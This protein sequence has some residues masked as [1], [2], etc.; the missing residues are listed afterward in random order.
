[1]LLGLHA[2]DIL[3]ETTKVDRPVL[4][5][6]SIGQSL[7]HYGNQLGH[8]AADGRQLSIFSKTQSG[9]KS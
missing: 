6:K 7:S 1:M 8:K 5:L 3:T 9:R 2:G 4:V